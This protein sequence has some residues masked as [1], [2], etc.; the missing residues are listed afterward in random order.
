MNEHEQWVSKVHPLA[1]DAE[2][3]D[4]YELMA[5]RV[6][7]DPEVMLECLLQEFLWMGW[8]ADQLWPLF[9]DPSYPLLQELQQHFGADELRR[10][11]DRLTKQ[12]GTLRFRES[13]AEPEEEPDVY[14]IR[15][16]FDA[17]T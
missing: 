5:E 12:W 6:P 8:D 16:P 7:G 10:R 17:A 9:H 15:L 2:P 13:I 14:E 3:E 4:P 1:R 11:L